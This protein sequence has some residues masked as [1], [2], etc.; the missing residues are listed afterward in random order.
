M[1]ILHLGI[2]SLGLL[3]L[4]GCKYGMSDNPF[5]VDDNPDLFD[6]RGR[7]LEAIGI[8]AGNDRFLV[9]IPRGVKGSVAEAINITRA[10]DAKGSLKGVEF[11]L[12]RGNS[13]K[14]SE[15][16]NLGQYKIV[17]TKEV[18]DIRN[19]RLLIGIHEKKIV[20]EATHPKSGLV[21]PIDATNEI[22][23]KKG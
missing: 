12:H 9:V 11:S 2:I 15:N 22:G 8:D 13:D 10:V 17:I 14:V 1:R 5:L 20:M 19:I 4:L 23:V 18:K 3:F 6:K 21:L 16:K 7:S